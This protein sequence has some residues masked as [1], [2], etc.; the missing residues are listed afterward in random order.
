VQQGA[1]RAGTLGLVAAIVAA[2]AA[3]LSLAS[4]AAA[5]EYAPLNRPGPKLEVPRKDLKASLKCSKGVRDA[6]R[7]PVL[8][9]PATGVDSEHNFAWNYE[10]AFRDRGIPFCTSDQ[11]GEL[12]SN[13]D[14]IQI[15]GDYVTYAIRR[16]HALAGRRIATLGHS[17]GGMITRW[18]L[19][20]WPDT[21]RMVDDV[22]GMAGSNHGSSGGGASCLP[23]CSAA[24]AQQSADSNFIAALNSRAETFER[25][26]YTEIYT[27]HDEVVT[28]PPS[29][30]VSGPGRITNVAIQSICPADPEEHLAIGTSDATAYALVIDALRHR[31]PAQPTRIDAG[32]CAQ[33]FMPGVNPA[34]Y[35]ADSA[36]SVAFLGNSIATYPHADGEP[37]LR[38]YVRLRCKRR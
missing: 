28:P 29:A 35:A 33:P 32:V 5:I 11:Q 18:S 37:P 30:G 16:M 20:F 7:E 34:T 21:R 6:K 10:R 4:A 26:S 17:Q 22:I 31:G 9:L 8:L 25:I 12:S 13:M 24:F 19:R 38:C 3:C 15:R 23:G 36:A 1:L 27:N 2:L 14:D